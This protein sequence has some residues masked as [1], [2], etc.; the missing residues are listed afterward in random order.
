[1]LVDAAPVPI[2]AVDSARNVVVW[3]R[4]AAATFGW[5]AD[6]VLGHPIPTVPPEREHE[7][8]G[9]RPRVDRGER[10]VMQTQRVRRDGTILDV[11]LTTV[12]IQAGGVV[13]PVAIV[14]DLTEVHA[15]QARVQAAEGRARILLDTVTDFAV[16]FLTADGRITDASRGAT[17]LLGESLTDAQMTDLLDFGAADPLRLAAENGRF[18]TESCSRAVR[19]RRFWADVVITALRDAQN[20]LTGY[21]AVLRD[22]T[23]R[24]A[25]QERERRRLQEASAVTA[26]AHRAAREATVEEVCDAAV[27][28]LA[29]AM[30]A[31]YTEFARMIDDS[32]VVTHA[33]GWGKSPQPTGRIDNTRDTFYAHAL[34]QREPVV[35][36]LTDTDLARAPHLRALGMRW[37]AAIAIRGVGS[38]AVLSA[39]TRD[40]PLEETDLYPLQSV[41]ALCEAIVARRYAEHQ[42]AE[43]DRTLTMMLNQMPAILWTVDRDMRFTSL[44]G[45]GLSVLGATADSSKGRPLTD[46]AS[47]EGPAMQTIAAA[48]GGDSGSY[49]GTYRGRTYDNRVEPLRSADGEIV[50]AMNLA[51][52]ITDRRR[53]EEA[54][55]VSHEEL[56]RLSVRLN[57]L[58]EEERRRIAHELH[59]ELGQRL[60]ALRMEA[61]LLPRKI[62]DQDA[63]RAAIDSMI[64]LIDE[65]IVEVRRVATE[66]RPAI[67][68]DVGFRAALEIELAT[69][70][71]RFG[72]DAT[73][74]FDPPDVKISRDLKTAL[75]RI[76][77]ESL[78]NVARHSGATLVRVSVELRDDAVLLEIADNGRG[79]TDEQ[80]AASSLGLVGMRERAYAHG[81]TVDVHRGANGGTVVSVRMPAGASQ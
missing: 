75:Y 69:L 31:D 51:L 22:V 74:A 72:I 8:S 25:A 30:Q 70:R 45:A 67:L 81:G 11:L 9:I 60:T 26:F 2:V 15:L 50:G 20:A 58:Q 38:P 6:E 24:K 16:L 47:A 39:F 73:I 49:I 13:Y 36:M 62:G 59:D 76:V 34:S 37:V 21:V 46:V 64:T 65:T 41:V 32:L 23:A 4:A 35:N 19:G 1:M 71:K 66:L 10:Y 3:N 29:A 33:F 52:D 80:L 61:A 44:Q 27:E 77:Q 79:I 17:M 55:R 42:L 7:L 48:L 54:L 14:Q 57:H 5:S 43:R 28:H 78:T 68:D 56:R 53:D 40:E 63:A 18:T 12:G